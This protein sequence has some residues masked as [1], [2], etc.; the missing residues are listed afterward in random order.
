MPSRRD[1]LFLSA[2]AAAAAPPMTSKQ[3]VD[4]ALRGEDVDRPPFTF[5]HHFGL[6]NE[7]PERHA[8]A[9]LDFHSKFRTDIVKVMSDFPY[10]RTEGRW[11][12]LVVESNPF[13]DQLKA[14]ELIRDGLNGQTYFVE[15]IFN[16]WNQAEKLSSKEEVRRMKD[17]DP[18]HLLAALQAI[19]E[20]EAN[21]A[22]KALAAG[23]SGIFLAIA[24]AQEG[25]L[26][27][28]EYARFSRPFDEFVLQSVAGAPLN[29]LHVHGDKPYLDLFYKGWPAAAINYSIHATGVPLADVR[30]R[31]GGV[32]MAG[33]DEVHFRTL[34]AADLG[35]QIQRAKDA[36]GK[37]FILA[38]GCSVPDPSTDEE[39]LRLPDLLGA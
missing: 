14:L 24:N 35:K 8:K 3:R 15:T 12:D 13:P 38:P 32:L 6:E 19:A 18:K 5:W 26:T 37:R 9:T 23:A 21:H 1:F 27:R 30:A 16:P 22:R 7:P 34:T 2:A 10:P 39:L 33:I 11:H 4:R 28:D 29:I 20:S 31:Y 25:I 17:Q 36:A